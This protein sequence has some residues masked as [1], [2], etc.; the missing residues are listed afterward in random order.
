MGILYCEL[1]YCNQLLFFK[2]MHYLN[3]LFSSKEEMDFKGERKL[4]DFN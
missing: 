3:E 2:H 4:R 1:V